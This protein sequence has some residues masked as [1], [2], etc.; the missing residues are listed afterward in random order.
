[1]K[2]DENDEDELLLAEENDDEDE[3]NNDN[4]DKIH[5]KIPTTKFV[6]DSLL[7]TF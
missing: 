3:E 2:T 5:M 7:K 6:F 4:S 1:M